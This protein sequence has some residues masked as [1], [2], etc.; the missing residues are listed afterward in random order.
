MGYYLDPVLWALAITLSAIAGIWAFFAFRRRGLAAGLRGVAWMLLP[1]A[2]LFTGT[3]TLLLRI[4][5]AVTAWAAR[6]VLNPMMWGG[7]LLLGLSVTLFVVARLLSARAPRQPVAGA[8]ARRAGSAVPADPVDP[9]MA[10]IEAL[11]RRR[12]IS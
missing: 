12:G 1:F 2:A 9:E 7:L 4:V 3:L 8:P 10:E 11:L 6:L 5:D